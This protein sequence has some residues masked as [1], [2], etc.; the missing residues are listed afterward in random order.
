[1]VPGLGSDRS[2]THRTAAMELS[3]EGTLHGDIT[4]R[5]NGEEALQHRL[6]SNGDDD[7]SRKK[8]WKMS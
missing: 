6:D 8:T 2:L 7:A 5:F 4:V 1:M 3:E